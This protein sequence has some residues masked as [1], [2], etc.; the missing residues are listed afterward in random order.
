MFVRND[1]GCTSTDVLTI[2]LQA[3]GGRRHIRRLHAIV[4]PD[5]SYIP[6][7]LKVSLYPDF[8]RNLQNLDCLESLER[9]ISNFLVLHS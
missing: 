5:T 4:S 7:L 2:G 1:R 6:K 3:S 8:D 9:G